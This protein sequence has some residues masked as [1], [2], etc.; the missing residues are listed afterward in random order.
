MQALPIS[1]SDLLQSKLDSVQL[2]TDL[3][4][5]EVQELLDTVVQRTKAEMDTPKDAEKLRLLNAVLSLIP[6]WQKEQSIWDLLGYKHYG[7]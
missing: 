6:Q 1:V 2:S 3:K 4:P 5:S 7:F